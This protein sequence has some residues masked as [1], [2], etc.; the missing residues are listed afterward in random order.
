[1]A[2]RGIKMILHVRQPTLH[3][4]SPFGMS[5]GGRTHASHLTSCRVA[6]DA[7]SAEPISLW[8]EAL[9]SK[10]VA[11]SRGQH[12][13][14]P[15]RAQPR[16][17]E[18]DGSIKHGMAQQCFQDSAGGSSIRLEA[19]VHQACLATMQGTWVSYSRICRCGRPQATPDARLNPL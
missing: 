7:T 15:T 4:G 3:V 2:A 11:R 6:Q 8:L 13:P 1:M 19:S 14:H 17:T 5:A 9:L 16:E 12:C 18:T 10:A